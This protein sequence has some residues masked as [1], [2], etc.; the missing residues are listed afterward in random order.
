MDG[1]K[2]TWLRPG[3]NAETNLGLVLIA[4]GGLLL[5]SNLGIIGSVGGI[6]GLLLFGSIGLWLLSGH[7]G[8]RRKNS[9]TLIAGFV[10]LGI[11][12]A[13]VTGRLGGVWFLAVSGF[14]FLSVWRENAKQ[15]WA[16]IPGGVLL[17]LAA[18]AFTELQVRFVAPEL[19]FFGGLALTFLALSALPRHAQR[20]A[21]IPAAV[22][23]GI[24]FLIWGASGSWLLPLL[25]IGGG[26][27]LLRG[28]QAG[29]GTA[30]TA[31]P[32]NGAPTAQAGPEGEAAE[33]AGEGGNSR[34]HLL[35]ESISSTG[36]EITDDWGADSSGRY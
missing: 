16:V 7:Y 10:L 19:V 12:A 23:A 11:A 36:P 6:T 30:F 32:R 1:K 5:L 33:G 27:W 24:A 2:N 4:I 9:G 25:L 8:G 17:T 3:G 21:L 18:T 28:R 29:Q 34:P 31:A 20:W 26:L 13:T 15:W 14:G 22:S 35:P